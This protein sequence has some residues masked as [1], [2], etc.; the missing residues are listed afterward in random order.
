MPSLYHYLSDVIRDIDPERAGR[1][2]DE[3]RRQLHGTVVFEAE[4]PSGVG[5]RVLLVR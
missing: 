5:L 4:Q 3:L 1:L 2:R